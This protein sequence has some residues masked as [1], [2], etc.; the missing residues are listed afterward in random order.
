MLGLLGFF[1]SDNEPRFSGTMLKVIEIPQ[2]TGRGEVVHVLSV[3]DDDVD[4]VDSLVVTLETGS[5]AFN[6]DAAKCKLSI[7]KVR[8][9]EN[10]SLVMRKPVFSSPVPKAH[11]VSL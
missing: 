1:I 10:V 5:S 4:D 7:V 3:T 11:K 6:F 2:S 9:T 8:I